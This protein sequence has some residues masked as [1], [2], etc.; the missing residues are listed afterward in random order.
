MILPADTVG[1][2]GYTTVRGPCQLQTDER[3]L[4]APGFLWEPNVLLALEAERVR[5]QSGT[6]LFGG[7]VSAMGLLSVSSSGR[8]AGAAILSREYT[9]VLRYS[10]Y[11][12]LPLQVFGTARQRID[13]V[14]I[15]AAIHVWAVLA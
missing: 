7:D 5:C 11:S 12:Q 1:F 13:G 3:V 8:I 10:S 14:P 9:D 2:G 6:S 15:I 4:T